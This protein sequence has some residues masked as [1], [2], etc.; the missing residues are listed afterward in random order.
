MSTAVMREVVSSGASLG[1]RPR[2]EMR[3]DPVKAAPVRTDPI[4]SWMLVDPDPRLAA[5]KRLVYDFWREVVEG[6]RLEF[7]SRYLT[8]SYTLHNPNVEAGRDAF[9]EFYSLITRPKPVSPRVMAPLT[10]M[11][12]DGDLVVMSFGSQQPDPADASKVLRSTWFD[13]FRIHDGRIAEQ[14]DSPARD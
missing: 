6:G 3:S 9:V 10:G 5:N 13:M 11:V 12:A 7:V 1:S 14:W 4:Q 8:K 2:N